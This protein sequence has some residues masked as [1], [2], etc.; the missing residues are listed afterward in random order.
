VLA[1]ARVADEENLDYVG[2]QDHPYQRRFLATR[3]LMATV[4]ARTERVSVF[5]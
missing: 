4:L 2:I 3:L 5:Q 1:L